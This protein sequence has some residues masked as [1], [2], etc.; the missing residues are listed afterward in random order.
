M[1]QCA[2]P[3]LRASVFGMSPQAQDSLRPAQPPRPPSSPHQ[4]LTQCTMSA[5]HNTLLLRR[6]TGACPF[7]TP[8]DGEG[9]S[10]P[11]A[12]A[13]LGN[14]PSSGTNH[15]HHPFYDRMKTPAACLKVFPTKPAPQEGRE[16]DDSNVGSTSSVP[17]ADRGLC[18]HGLT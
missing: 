15:T 3:S 8:G 18:R 1:C 17:S 4:I 5:E 16:G 7:L 9:F 6:C 12:A 10:G 11:Q 14:L 13:H 2:T